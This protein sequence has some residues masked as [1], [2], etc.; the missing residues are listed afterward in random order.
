MIHSITINN[1]KRSNFEYVNKTD[2]KTIDI[3]RKSKVFNFTKGLN[4]IIGE[5]GCGKSTLINMLGFY[6]FSNHG[7]SKL[8]TGLNSYSIN[9]FFNYN[10]IPCDG[11]NVINDYSFKVFKLVLEHFFY[12]QKIAISKLTIILCNFES[13]TNKR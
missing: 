6:T 2:S 3:L 4:L 13:K 7:E 12:E 11:I 10:E 8:K 9:K 1:L 5:N